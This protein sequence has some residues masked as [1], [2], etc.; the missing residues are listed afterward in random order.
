V[1]GV[2]RATSFVSA[3]QLTASI[4]ASDIVTTGAATITV[5]TPAPGGGTSGGQTLTV[6][7]PS[8]SVNT[9]SAVP[10][11]TVT[12]TLTNSPGGAD[13]LGL[14]QVGAPDAS[15][16]QWVWVGAG[17]TS[18][19]WT[20]TMPATRGQYEFRFFPN[21]ATVHAATSPAVT[22]GN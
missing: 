9:T 13:W 4:L 18:R 17:L 21:Y 19:T 5:F 8:L 7:A 12:A 15:Y 1:N 10:G 6:M 20:V 16:L 14:F 3:T 2:N 22:V 11:G